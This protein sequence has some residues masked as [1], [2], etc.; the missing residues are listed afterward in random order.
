[1]SDAVTKPIGWI[2]DVIGIGGHGD[3]TQPGGNVSPTVPYPDGGTSPM[4]PVPPPMNNDPNDRLPPPNFGPGEGDPL[5]GMTPPPAPPTPD[6]PAVQGAIEEAVKEETKKAGRS[7]AAT[8]LTGGRGLLKGPSI[9][10]R[11][12]LGS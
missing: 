4:T 2:G 11:M 7:R 8:V 9:A 1:M 5:D 12:L 6:N 3:P 10:R